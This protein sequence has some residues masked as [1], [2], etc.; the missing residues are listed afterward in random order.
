MLRTK[1]TREAVENNLTRSSE[2][3]ALWSVG[4]IAPLEVEVLGVIEADQDESTAET[5]ENVGA[6]T[7]EESWDTLLNE[8]LAEAVNG[9]LVLAGVFARGHHHTTTDGVQWVG[10]ETS[11]N[12]HGVADGELHQEV[13]V[14]DVHLGGIIETEVGTAVEDDTDAR[15]DETV[16]DTSASPT[17]SLG[18]LH[19]AVEGT[20]ELA[21]RAFADIDGKTGTG[22]VEWVH[23][24]QRSGT[25]KTTR[26]DVAEEARPETGGAWVGEPLLV[27]VLE[28]K[29][30]SLGGEVT[31]HVGPVTAPESSDTLLL[32][33]TDNAVHDALVWLGDGGILSL[34][35]EEKLDALNGSSNSLGDTGGD[36]SKHEVLNN[37]GLL[38]TSLLALGHLG[39]L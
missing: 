38:G 23:D 30:Q 13:G 18:G 39:D 19:D 14:G 7:L 12:G 26:G 8:N 33:D 24:Q 25:S 34:V 22:E 15:N 35:L 17:G 32:G 36:T 21:R 16:V 28:G 20:G 4:A 6:C 27:E 37:V 2:G 31:E 5:T 9:A 11:K 1:A 3:L 10:D 29:V